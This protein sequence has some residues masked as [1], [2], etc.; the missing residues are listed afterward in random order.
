MFATQLAD[1]FEQWLGGLRG[2]V[3]TTSG[4]ARQDT[5]F[6]LQLKAAEQALDGAQRHGELGSD[7]V[8]LALLLPAAK[9]SPD[10]GEQRWHGA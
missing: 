8:R 7:H 6:A 4:V 3:L 9:K 5:P 1:L 2:L 10:G